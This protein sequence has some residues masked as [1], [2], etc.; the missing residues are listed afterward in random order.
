[1]EGGARVA[2]RMRDE[3]D[4]EFLRRKAEQSAAGVL[5]NVQ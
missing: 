3:G 2:Y 4:L 5:S 1:L